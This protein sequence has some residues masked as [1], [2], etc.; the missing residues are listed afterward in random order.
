MSTGLVAAVVAVIGLFNF[1]TVQNARASAN[2]DADVR[3]RS[4]M[5]MS[6]Y[7]TVPSSS[8]GSSSSSSSAS[9]PSSWGDGNPWGTGRFYYKQNRSVTAG[10]TETQESTDGGTT[11]SGSLKIGIVGITVGPINTTDATKWTRVVTATVAYT[12]SCCSPG[13]PGRC[14]YP[15]CP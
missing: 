10:T 3:Y 14:D 8:S 12:F 4:L 7:D 2:T 15:S 5:M 11:W 9:I 1:S 6:L 13:T